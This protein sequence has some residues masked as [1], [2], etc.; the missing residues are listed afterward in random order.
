MQRYGSILTL[1]SGGPHLRTLGD[2]RPPGLTSSDVTLLILIVN[3]MRFGS[4]AAQRRYF[5]T[6]VSQLVF[7]QAS[8]VGYDSD[9]EVG[10]HTN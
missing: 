7:V 8:K 1:V 2:L 9:P 5:L 4:R 3:L 10:N 6:T